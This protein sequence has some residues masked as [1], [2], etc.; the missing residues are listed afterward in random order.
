MKKI[1]NWKTIDT[2]NFFYSIGAVVIL[3][4]VIAKFLEWKSQDALLLAGL[5]VEALVFTFSSIQQKS[6]TVVY[7]WENIFPELITDE[8]ANTISNTQDR[9]N[10]LMNKYINFLEKSIV[11]FEEMNTN[12]I[13]NNERFQSVISKSIAQFETSTVAIHELNNSIKLAA[14]S[15][16]DFPLIENEIIELTENL[17]VVN[18]NS[19][20]VQIPLVEFNNQLVDLK[21][22][23]SDFTKLGNGILG[24]F[25]S[26]DKK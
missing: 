13:Q 4:G 11:L 20:N 18:V 21:E 9:Y 22:T 14:Y 17:R 25:R 26:L 8:N 3:I 16:K 5:S 1:Q 19:S 24:Q 15:I 12:T 7:K 10:F 6:S 2:M 23:F